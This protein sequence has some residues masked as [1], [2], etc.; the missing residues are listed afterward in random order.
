MPNFNHLRRS[1]F[2]ENKMWNSKETKCGGVHANRRGGGHAHARAGQLLCVVAPCV[3]H[4]EAGARTQRRFPEDVPFIILT[5]THYASENEMGSEAPRDLGKND[6]ASH[7]A[8]SLRLC[9]KMILL[10]LSY[11][12]TL[13]P[14]LKWQ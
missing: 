8:V 1:L 2:C 3:R 12:V 5:T 10:L 14:V 6:M 13:I 11:V 4:A 9:N 7:I